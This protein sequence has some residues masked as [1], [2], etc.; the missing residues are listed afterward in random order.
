MAC[1]TPPASQIK[2]NVWLSL[3]Q[4]P[5]LPWVLGDPRGLG[6]AARVA[7]GRGGGRVALERDL[8]Q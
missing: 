7:G 8:V 3:V 4:G 5:L 6:V 1:D 2:C